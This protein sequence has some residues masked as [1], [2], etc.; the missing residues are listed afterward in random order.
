MIQLEEDEKRLLRHLRRHGPLP[1][2]RLADALG[3]SNARLTRLSAHLIAHGLI[4]EA[5][6]DAPGQRGRP[7]TP[8][9]IAAGAGYA[10]GATV[11]R[12]LIEVALVDYAGGLID[13]AAEPFDSPDPLVFARTVRRQLHRMAERNRLLGI[14]VGV[15]GPSLS[16]DGSRRSTVDSL[17]GWRGIELAALFE[18]A[19]GHPV[20]I[21]NDA[22]AAALAEF[23]RGGLMQRCETAVVI[24][25]GHGIGAGIINEGRLMRGE[26]AS[27]GEI[28]TLYP[29]ERP[30][31]ST[32]DLLATLRAAGCPVDSLIDLDER[33]DAYQ[34]TIDAWVA[35]A[36]RQLARIMSWGLAWI[37]PGAFVL[38]SPLPRP[39]LHR[40]A[41]AIEPRAMRIGGHRKG[42]PQILVSELGGLATTIGAALLP[43]HATL[44]TD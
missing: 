37:D 1:R 41:A 7:A 9:R 23:Y 4:E 19:F 26:M 3:A 44:F 30:R 10:L 14:G 8:L 5:T 29:I 38:S 36:G 27:A 15:P 39:I 24:L 33:L 12:G 40:L 21:E 35:R 16:R 6:S 20:W 42:P 31:P 11:H 25:L 2:G 28:G 17:A 32:L 43:V 34:A 13:Q 22:N 18:E